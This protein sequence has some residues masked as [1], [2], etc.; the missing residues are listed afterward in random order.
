MLSWCQFRLAQAL[1]PAPHLTHLELSED[2]EVRTGGL[3]RAPKA[4][5]RRFSTEQTLL[6]PTTTFLLYFSFFSWAFRIYR[7]FL[8]VL[9]S[10][11]HHLRY[12][13]L[14]TP[15]CFEPPPPDRDYA[16]VPVDLAISTPK[17]IRLPS[18]EIRMADTTEEAEPPKDAMEGA[19]ATT[20]TVA[21]EGAV[22]AMGATEMRC[23]CGKEDC[24]FLRHNCS[25]LLSVERDVHVAAKMGQVCLSHSFRL[26][27]SSS[28]SLISP[29]VRLLSRGL[30]LGLSL[31]C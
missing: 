11:R 27:D 7:V 13:I 3:C 18:S 19:G 5:R 20:M 23:C 12:L 9:F 22:E 25:V 28:F 4:T 8:V 1:I 14:H 30:P 17:N 21:A 2:I 29:S 16:V 24:V 15:L 31:S 6:K 26:P 10:L